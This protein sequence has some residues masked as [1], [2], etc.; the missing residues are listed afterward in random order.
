[1]AL[2]LLKNFSILV[3]ILSNLQTKGHSFSF[4][5]PWFTFFPW[6]PKTYS[7]GLCPTSLFLGS[8]TILPVFSP[9]LMLECSRAQFLVPSYLSTFI[10]SRISSAVTA[11]NVIY[12]PVSQSQ[13][14]ISIPD[15]I[16]K[17]QTSSLGYLKD[18]PTPIK[19]H[20]S[21]WT[22]DNNAILSDAQAKNLHPAFVFLFPFLSPSNWTDCLQIKSRIQPFLTNSTINLFIVAFDSLTFLPGLCFP[23]K[24]FNYQLVSL[25]LAGV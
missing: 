6:I 21:N 7:L 4:L 11:L 20:T 15:V 25:F 17:L 10:S 9:L 1:M 3:S 23:P 19:F 13:L 2:T 24:L 16:P 5:L 18:T 14:C 22:P 8:F 12:I